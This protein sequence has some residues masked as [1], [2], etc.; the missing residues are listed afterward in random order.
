MSTPA[1]NQD[2]ISS[3]QA[4]LWA[5]LITVHCV[6]L[7]LAFSVAITSSNT[8]PPY[9]PYFATLTLIGIATTLICFATAA[10]HLQEKN[11]LYIPKM[12]VSIF[13]STYRP[14]TRLISE[15][16]SIII[17]LINSIIILTAIS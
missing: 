10:A 5:A 9:I 12:K 14:K 2:H 16:T 11:S 17:L 13:W 6:F 15:A 3:I 7:A 4:A 8:Q 1:N